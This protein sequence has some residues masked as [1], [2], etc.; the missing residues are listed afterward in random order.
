MSSWLTEIAGKAE[1]FLNA[2]DKGA[3][4]ALTNVSLN[5]R[6]TR[7]NSSSSRNAIPNDSVI[8]LDG[9]QL[10][11]HHD[12]DFIDT[13]DIMSLKTSPS[14]N[15]LLSDIG[16]N[17]K[18]NHTRTSSYDSNVSRNSKIIDDEQ[19]ID[20]LNQKDD[21]IP[22]EEWQSLNNLAIQT[23]QIT[24]SVSSA[25]ERTPKKLKDSK[26]LIDENEVLSRK[27]SEMM[28][29]MKSLKLRS[30]SYYNQN[31]Q[32][33]KLVKELQAKENDNLAS[34]RA[35]E[36]QL[37]AL[38]I[39]SEQLAFD[40][41][42]KENKC[43]EYERLNEQLS[44]QIKSFS[45]NLVK[46]LREEIQT[47][48]ESLRLEKEDSKRLHEQNQQQISRLEDNQKS[49]IVELE[50]YR[51]QAEQIKTKRD[52]LELERNCFQKKFDS[53][54]NEFEQF[55]I[56]ASK[57]LADKETLLNKLNEDIAKR[58][59]LSSNVESSSH[60]ELVSNQLLQDQCNTLVKELTELRT[61]Y[62]S[63]KNLLEKT[64]T[65]TIPRFDFQIK[66]LDNELQRERESN[67]HLKAEITILSRESKSYQDELN[68]VR[69]S[70]SARLTE[71]DEEIDT[72]RKQLMLKRNSSFDNEDNYENT[73]IDDNIDGEDCKSK[74]S[75]KQ[76][77]NLSRES[78][79]Q[80]WSRMKSLTENLIAK[81]TQIEQLS[82]A[83]HSLKLQ[84]ERSEQKIRELFA[85]KT[86]SSNDVAIGI[87]HSPTFANNLVKH[88][89][90]HSN[91]FSDV[92]PLMNVNPD[93]SQVARK[94]KNAYSVIDSFSIR[95]GNFLRVYPS[96]RAAFLL[97]IIILHV[98][99]VFVL[100]YYEP[101]IH[102]N[103]FKNHPSR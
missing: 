93:D 40:L 8:N 26:K 35:K 85:N 91:Q 90:I 98:W 89:M 11:F 83:N 13:P 43:R 30:Q 39:Q 94:V 61:Q 38:K 42:E 36:S 46:D 74:I 72:L 70:L 80:E 33:E 79:H 7:E 103:D 34:I 21:S 71:R 17:G 82:S 5:S 53:L 84:L 22:E 41:Q 28:N 1:N 19:S 18:K 73:S 59:S 63:M 67:K 50:N 37:A 44:Q 57:T 64:E 9:N 100:M 86:N 88:R 23:E 75:L 65:E 49:L 87:Y 62:D 16:N 45:D 68:Q 29:E 102:G 54:R 77:Q 2:V 56:K 55:K 4:N 66:Q 27:N 15:S 92:I 58:P 69:S 96:A 52:E 97:Y 24:S 76:K 32:N 14:T 10:S 3:A 12:T 95:L 60:E 6:N 78:Q 101:E 25:Q 47:L 81:Q 51:R 48:T 20:I 99:V 31:A